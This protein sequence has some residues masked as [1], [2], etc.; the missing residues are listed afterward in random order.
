ML[1]YHGTM[2]VTKP[3]AINDRRIAYQIVGA[4]ALTSI[5]LPVLVWIAV[6]RSAALA[7][8]IGGG[9]A[10][11]GNLYFAVQAF[12]YSGARASRDMVRA[13]YRGEAG[14]FVIVMVLFI[15]AFRL[16]DGI[17]ETAPFMLCGFFLVYALA[18]IAPLALAKKP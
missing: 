4:Q 6:G 18:W 2:A 1:N 11:T 5:V 12:R 10:T 15:T 16:V 17:R 14:K 8:L 3:R 7:T 9:I 13:F